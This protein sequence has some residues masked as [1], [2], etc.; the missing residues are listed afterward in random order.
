MFGG[1]T[2]EGRR[3]GDVWALSTSTWSWRHVPSI[4]SAPSPRWGA[5]AAMWGDSLVVFGGTGASAL[6]NDVWL[7]DI[8]ESEVSATLAQQCSLVLFGSTW[9]VRERGGYWLAR[10]G[11]RVLIIAPAAA[12]H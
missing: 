9:P 11:T 10:A 3:L 8:S 4:G 6:L 5:A 2:Q 12:Q 7:L 1:R